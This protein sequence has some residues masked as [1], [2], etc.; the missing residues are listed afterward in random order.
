MLAWS[1][2]VY[3]RSMDIIEYIDRPR[4]RDE[5]ISGEASQCGWFLRDLLHLFFYLS[6]PRDAFRTG[7]LVQSGFKLGA[8]GA[9]L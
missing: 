5:V 7:R 4:I 3:F 6:L 1:Y 8:L 9:A 2:L